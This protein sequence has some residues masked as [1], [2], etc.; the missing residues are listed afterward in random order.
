MTPHPHRDIT[1][2]EAKQLILVI[3]YSTSPKDNPGVD[4]HWHSL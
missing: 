2:D 1:R 3:A 4:S